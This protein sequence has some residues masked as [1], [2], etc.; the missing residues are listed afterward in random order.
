[1]E[2]TTQVR[3]ER[4]PE[5]PGFPSR[6]VR[7]LP[8]DTQY[9]NAEDDLRVGVGVVV[10]ADFA[11]RAQ[12]EPSDISVKTDAV[13]GNSGPPVLNRQGE[14]VGLLRHHTHTRGKLT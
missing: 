8:S 6:T 5:L 14:V 13:S 10:E 2:A 3:I 1:M 4:S 7:D 12:S 9:R 11:A